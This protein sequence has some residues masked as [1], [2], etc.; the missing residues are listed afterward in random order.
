MKKTVYSCLWPALALCWLVASPA[1]AQT[2]GDKT[3]QQNILTL[4]ADARI[5]ATQDLMTLTLSARS[6]AEDAQQAQAQLQQAINESMEIVK[7]SAQTGQMDV[8]SGQ[9]NISPSHDKQGKVTTWSGQAS[10]ILEGRDFERITQAAARLDA[11][12]I[13][14]IGF[15]LSPERREKTQSQAQ[16]Q[17]VK[18]FRSN[19]D[20]LV[21][22]FGFEHYKL[23]QVNISSGY[24]GPIMRPYGMM[25]KAAMA[26]E[27]TP[28][29]VQAGQSV[30]T[31]T[32][33]GSVQAY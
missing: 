22:A 28:V 26:D 1:S 24:D 16:L 12:S 21:R 4:S 31:V 25:A 2:A 9:F 18:N 29:T 32:V 27:A 19:A 13:T 23:Q 8:R 15:G 7:A 10:I 11:M 33:S 20:E 14:Q 17:A 6:Q 3:V 30:V 5:E